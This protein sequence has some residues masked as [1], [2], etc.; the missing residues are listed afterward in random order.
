MIASQSSKHTLPVG[1]LGRLIP[2]VVSN[3]SFHEYREA[4]TL[5]VEDD[6]S[7]SAN[8]PKSRLSSSS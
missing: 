7:I 2:D 8:Y 6:R 4:E 3:K 1:A 5:S